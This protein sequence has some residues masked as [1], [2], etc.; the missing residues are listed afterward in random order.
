MFFDALSGSV[1]EG[2]QLESSNSTLITRASAVAVSAPG[3]L[4]IFLLAMFGLF[5]LRTQKI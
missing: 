2:M 4:S 1:L 3:T 5:G